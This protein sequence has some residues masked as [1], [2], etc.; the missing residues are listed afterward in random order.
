[1]HRVAAASRDEHSNCT[2]AFVCAVTYVVRVILKCNGDNM[3]VK[4]ISDIAR[5]GGV[6]SLSVKSTE[7]GGPSLSLERG[8]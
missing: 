4:F 2:V 1:M 6:V 7:S 8:G 3:Y 5:L